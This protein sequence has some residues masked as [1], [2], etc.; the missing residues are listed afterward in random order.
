MTEDSIQRFHH[1]MPLQIRFN[2]IDKFGHVNN[3]IYFQYYDTAKIDYFDNVC[4]NVDWNKIAIV[5]AKIETEFIAQV[6]ADSH[7]EALTRVTRVGNK[8]FQLEQEIVSTDTHEVKSR[9]TSVMVLYDLEKRCSISFPNNWREAI[10][11]YDGIT[12]NN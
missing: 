5:A 6:K 8:S 3:S 1:V 9:C 4:E 12:P 7:V 10:Y 2:D 11:N